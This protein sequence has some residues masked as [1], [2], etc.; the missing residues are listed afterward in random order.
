[1]EIKDLILSKIK[2]QKQVTSAEIIKQTG[3]SRTFVNRAFQELRDEG[4]ILLLGKA[5]SAIYILAEKGAIARAKKPVLKFNGKFINKNITEEVILKKIKD[6]TGIFLDLKRNVEEIIS[7]AFLEMTNN[8]IEHSRSVAI[9]ISMVRDKNSISF[10]VADAGIGIFANIKNEF[11]LP[12]ILSAIQFLL[13]GKH[14]TAPKGHSGQGIF[15]TSKIADGFL[16]KSFGKKVR[17]INVGKVEDVFLEDT[18]EKKGTVIFFSM[19]KDS[20]KNLRDVFTDYTEKDTFEFSKTKVVV[21]L[22]KISRN[23]LSRSEARRIVLGLEDFKEVFLDFKGVE[24][25]GQGFVDEI[26]RVW[27]TAHPKKKI[28]YTNANENVEFMIKRTG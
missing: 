3:F 7:Y 14:T 11:K 25:V 16:I 15:F 13:K 12:D 9:N 22:Y 5:N 6:Q 27:Q 8:A 28:D 2:K 17:F 4:K 21:A 23:L 1:M 24:T 19:S 18:K 10:T 20:R 26:F